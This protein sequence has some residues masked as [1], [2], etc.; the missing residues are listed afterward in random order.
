MEIPGL[1]LPAV[2]F[3]ASM[4]EPVRARAR[5]TVRAQN[6]APVNPQSLLGMVEAQKR[7]TSE[8]AIVPI[9]QAPDYEVIDDGHDDHRSHE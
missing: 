8:S 6:M 2:I 5:K 7:L 3:R 4:I 9:P 1:G